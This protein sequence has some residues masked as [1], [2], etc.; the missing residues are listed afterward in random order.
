MLLRVDAAARNGA[1]RRVV[2]RVSLDDLRPLSLRLRVT[3]RSLPVG[4]AQRADILASRVEAYVAREGIREV[5]VI[6]PVAH[7]DI[8]VCR[9]DLFS[10]KMLARLPRKKER[11]LPERSESVRL[12]LRRL[13]RT[14]VGSDSL[15]L[16]PSDWW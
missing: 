8:R 14:R 11:V 5:T 2:F 6:K 1:I 13:I 15:L 10:P 9:V 7:A 4:G 16:L 12:A 3:V